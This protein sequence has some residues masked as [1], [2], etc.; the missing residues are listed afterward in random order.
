MPC[1]SFVAIR[2]RDSVELFE[3]CRQILER[4]RVSG[5]GH[6]TLGNRSRTT[7]TPTPSTSAPRPEGLVPGGE[8]EGARGW[9]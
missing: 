8:A 3:T 9:P 2:F 7:R 6:I 4:S 1:C 5:R